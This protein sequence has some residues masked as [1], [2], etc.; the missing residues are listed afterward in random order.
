MKVLK[1]NDCE[2]FKGIYRFYDTTLN[3]CITARGSY[4]GYIYEELICVQDTG[5]STCPGD[6]GG[7]FTVMNKKKQHYL[8]GV[9]SKNR[10]CAEVI[11]YRSGCYS[12]LMPCNVYSAPEV[13]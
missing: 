9:V 6:S 8:A 7:P 11:F 4:K 10:G 13:E 1:R 5:K 12:W 2:K 3:R